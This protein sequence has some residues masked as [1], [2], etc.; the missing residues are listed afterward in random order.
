MLIG[1]NGR[2]CMYSHL[3]IFIKILHILLPEH[4]QKQVFIDLW[5][6]M[7]HNP[8]RKGSS[9]ITLAKQRSSISNNIKR[10]NFPLTPEFYYPHIWILERGL[11]AP[12]AARM[13]N[14]L[15]SLPN[16]YQSYWDKFLNF[17]QINGS[18]DTLTKLMYQIVFICWIKKIS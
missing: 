12:S 2:Y 8:I 14:M 15:R 18:M 10:K 9:S 11:D 7:V 13:A 1:T 6:P 17:L 4:Y 3:Q 5:W 16:H